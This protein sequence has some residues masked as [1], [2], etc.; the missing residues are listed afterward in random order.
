MP[1]AR[2]PDSSGSSLH[3]RQ[4]FSAQILSMMAAKRSS[5]SS[6][7][8]FGLRWCE[9]VVRGRWAHCRLRRAVLA[10]DL[11]LDAGLGH[12]V[13]GVVVSGCVGGEAVTGC[14]REGVRGLSRGVEGKW[15]E[16]KSS[17]VG[18][19]QVKSEVSEST[20][21]CERQCSRL[22][23]RENAWSSDAWR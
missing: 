12:C 6:V 4:R 18:R 8:G 21:Q 17:E 1:L 20:L 7:Q 23:R 22:G 13:M 19:S 5:S 9:C 16:V 10:L 11:G 15:G 2:R 3:S 14:G